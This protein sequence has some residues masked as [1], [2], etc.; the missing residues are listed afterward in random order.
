MSATDYAREKI[1]IIDWIIRQE[2]ANNLK[3][4]SE[5]IQR[6]EKESAES[7]RIVG[8]RAKGVAVTLNQLIVSIQS[9]LD[10]IAR[11][12]E[13]SLENLEQDSDQW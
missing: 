4:V 1:Q 8:Y 12:E 9:S 5:F 10:E 7:V 2:N 11:G 6:M 3:A 13:I